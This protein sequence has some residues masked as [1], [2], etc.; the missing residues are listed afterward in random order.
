MFKTWVATTKV[1]LGSFSCFTPTM[2]LLHFV[3]INFLLASTC[4]AASS[5]TPVRSG[6]VTEGSPPRISISDGHNIPVYGSKDMV[7]VLFAG[8]MPWKTAGQPDEEDGL[9]PMERH[10]WV[11]PLAANLALLAF[12]ERMVLE[13]PAEWSGYNFHVVF[14]D[15]CADGQGGQSCGAVWSI[16]QV[17]RYLGMDHNQHAMSAMETDHNQHAMSAMEMDEHQHAGRIRAAIASGLFLTAYGQMLGALKIPTLA[18]TGEERVLSDR[19]NYP[20]LARVNAGTAP[21]LLALA[22]LLRQFNYTKAVLW[23]GNDLS[24]SEFREESLEILAAAGVSLTTLSYAR[25][26]DE[27]WELEF[28]PPAEDS[29]KAREW[30]SAVTRAIA[31]GAHVHIMSGAPGPRLPECVMWLE[32]RR[33][34]GEGILWVHLYPIDAVYERATAVLELLYP[35]S[36]YQHALQRR[37]REGGGEIDIRKLAVGAKAID[38]DEYWR[39][40]QNHTEKLEPW[41]QEKIAEQPGVWALTAAESSFAHHL[42]FDSCWAVFTAMNKLLLAQ[43]PDFTSEALYQEILDSDFEAVSGRMAFS[44]DSTRET[45]V[46]IAQFQPEWCQRPAAA[47]GLNLPPVVSV[48]SFSNS[49]GLQLDHPLLFYGCRKEAP[50]DEQLPCAP[51]TFYE[52]TKG[53]CLE[54]PKGRVTRGVGELQC[55]DCSPG[56]FSNSSGGSLCAAC[57]FGSF[58]DEVA[59]TACTACS[60]GT[61]Q[62]EV[63]R[64]NC[65]TCPPGTSASG[66]GYAQCTPCA[67]GTYSAADGATACEACASEIAGSTTAHIHSVSSAACVCPAGSYLPLEGVA[68]APCPSSMVCALGSDMRNYYDHY[69]KQQGHLVNSG[70]TLPEAEESSDSDMVS[71]S[72]VARPGAAGALG[73]NSSTNSNENNAA[74]GSPVTAPGFPVAELGYMT[75][76]DDPLTVY[77]CL[78]EEHCPGGSPGTCCHSRDKSSV[79]CG[80][81]A[82]GR[83]ELWRDC[84]KCHGLHI[85]GIFPLLGVTLGCLIVTLLVYVVNGSA[86]N[87]PATSLFVVTMCGLLYTSVQTLGVFSEVYVEWVEPL[88]SLVLTARV[89]SFDLQLLRLACI[90]GPDPLYTFLTSQALAAVVLPAAAVTLFLRRRGGS[91][92][93]CRAASE[94][95]REGKLHQLKA[96]SRHSFRAEFLNSVGAIYTIFFISMLISSLSPFV[97]YNHPG[98]NGQSMRSSPAMLCS[99]DDPQH[100]TLVVIG[101]LVMCSFPLPFL[102][103]CCYATWVYPSR[104]AQL[105]STSFL[106]STRFLFVCVN[107]SRHYFQLL[108]MFRGLLLCVV[109]VILTSKPA[110]QVLVICIVLGSYLLIEEELRPWRAGLCNLF[111]AIMAVL[112]MVVLFIGGLFLTGDSEKPAM[113][114]VSSIVLGLMLVAAVAGFATVLWRRWLASFFD[115]FICHHKA[116]AAAQARFLK[117]LLQQRRPN[118]Q[119]FIDSDDLRDLAVLF[120]IIKSRVKQVVVYLTGDTLKRSWCIGEVT[121]AYYSKVDITRVETPTFLANRSLTPAAAAANAAL[122]LDPVDATGGGAATNLQEYG[123]Q[124]SEVVMALQWLLEEAKVIRLNLANLGTLRFRSLARSIASNSSAALVAAGTAN[125]SSAA[126]AADVKQQSSLSPAAF[127]A[128]VSSNVVIS[129]VKSSDEANAAGGILMAEITESVYRMNGTGVFLLADL[130]TTVDLMGSIAPIV[131]AAIVILSDGTMSCSE[132]LTLAAA[133]MGAQGGARVPAV[134]PL[135]TPN[136]EFPSSGAIDDAVMQLTLRENSNISSRFLRNFFKVLSVSWPTHASQTALHTQAG[137]VLARISSHLENGC[138]PTAR[139][140]IAAA[141]NGGGQSRFSS[142]RSVSYFSDRAGSRTSLASPRSSQQSRVEMGSRANSGQDW[143]EAASRNVSVTHYLAG[144]DPV[145]ESSPATSVSQTPTHSTQ[146]GSTE[147]VETRVAGASQP[148]HAESAEPVV[149]LADLQVGPVSIVPQPS[150]SASGDPS[151]I[152]GHPSHNSLCPT[153]TSTQA[154]GPL[155]HIKDQQEQLLSTSTEMTSFH[156]ALMHGDFKEIAC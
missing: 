14:A 52:Y 125:S 75:L 95:G 82:A 149:A 50:L 6:G 11:I 66:E 36:P 42:V 5:P 30:E 151:F 64:S 141:T 127:L 23:H 47:A 29:E 54:C 45:L 70:Q 24:E 16:K 111:D 153:S 8:I 1:P 43:G 57:D 38:F 65:R 67:V 10:Q 60:A 118:A 142:E 121:T 117:M 26:S 22:A 21:E 35:E 27:N 19:F 18:Y 86:H 9:H 59:A 131:S 104:M 108:V 130:E 25:Q 139:T 77:R 91:L 4:L 83:H 41:L 81:C 7:V 56:T 51:G 145:S 46:R 80:T 101:T 31:T 71:A 15:T 78:K 106:H 49:Q 146:P 58:S 119:V 34:H 120:D 90:W 154:S 61:F 105:N 68:C 69:Q 39:S 140:P 48:G 150:S 94:A 63:L 84:V 20:Y 85:D 128:T 40:M 32:W 136:F 97:C 53:A 152:V 102:A 113:V 148:G 3:F 147:S 100:T 107:P 76:E 137:E 92:L 138:R 132:Q 124:H 87:T 103:L 72:F 28:A 134:I 133:L 122:E 12:K 88:Q 126:A 99:G 129:T 89:L 116:D 123:F 62:D 143:C 55:Q 93:C 74:V 79:A 73:R 109:P 135:S 114:I 144:I 155:V 96:E 2:T 110:T 37:M 112:L 44:S 13:S 33:F 156:F 17:H 115:Y 98:G